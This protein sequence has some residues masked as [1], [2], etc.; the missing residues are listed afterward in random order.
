MEEK[1]TSGNV[2][3]ATVAPTYHLF[4]VDEV[5]AVLERI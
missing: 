4:T 2:D 5:A 1:V 3:I